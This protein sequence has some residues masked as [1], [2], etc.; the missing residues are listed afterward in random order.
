[1]PL[2]HA[3][4]PCYSASNLRVPH[5][6]TPRPG[7][8]GPW[9]VASAAHQGPGPAVRRGQG[10]LSCIDRAS[11]AQPATRRWRRRMTG[12]P[13]SRRRLA[14]GALVLVAAFGLH[15]RPDRLAPPPPAAPPPAP[16]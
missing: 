7:Q 10:A 9:R 6:G 4:W 2:E 3:G 8:S 16:P 11:T 12:F 13:L 1:M 14:L 15:A 5:I